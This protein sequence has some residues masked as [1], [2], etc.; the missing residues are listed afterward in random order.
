[1]GRGASLQR[2]SFHLSRAPDSSHDSLLPCHRAHDSIL[3]EEPDVED[4]HKDNL[5]HLPRF[6][7]FFVFWGAGIEIWEML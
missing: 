1:M 3:A 7:D 6:P 5:R 4:Y 2:P